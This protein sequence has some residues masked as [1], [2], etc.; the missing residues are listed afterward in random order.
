MSSNRILL[1]DDNKGQRVTLESILKSSGFHVVTADCGNA[2]LTLVENEDF[3]AALLDIK[4]P[5]ITG[6]EVL[7]VLKENKPDITVIMM[8][9]YSDTDYAI[10]ALN[11]GASAY[12][13]K[14]VNIE[15]IKALLK[16]QSS[17]SGWSRKI[18]PWPPPC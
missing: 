11:A 13:I 17:I 18:R 3:A 15:H 10:D 1:V 6:I 12:L 4:M 9:G 8:T 5:D 2:A 7:K 16:T 14:P